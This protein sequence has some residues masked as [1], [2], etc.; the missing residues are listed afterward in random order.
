MSQANPFL[1]TAVKDSPKDRESHADELAVLRQK[2]H[3]LKEALTRYTMTA[4]DDSDRD[5]GQSLRYR[6]EQFNVNLH[7]TNRLKVVRFMD[8]MQLQDADEYGTDVAQKATEFMQYWE[9]HALSG[10]QV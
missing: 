8:D 2:L 4:N 7:D 9:K 5:W 6:L 3:A 1:I 10:A